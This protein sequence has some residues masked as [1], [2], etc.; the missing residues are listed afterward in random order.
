MKNNPAIKIVAGFLLC[1]PIGAVY[2]SITGA[3]LMGCVCGAFFFIAAAVGLLVSSDRRAT[4]VVMAAIIYL[5]D[6]G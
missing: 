1:F 3:P 6:W 2:S 5:R 4:G